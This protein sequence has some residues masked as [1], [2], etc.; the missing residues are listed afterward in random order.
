M[1]RLAKLRE[2]KKKVTVTVQWFKFLNPGELV[3]PEKNAQQICAIHAE[4]QLLQLVLVSRTHPHL[5]DSTGWISYNQ[6]FKR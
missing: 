6:H 2:E 1:H 5:H 3:P 4:P